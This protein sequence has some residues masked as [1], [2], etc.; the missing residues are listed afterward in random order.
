MPPEPEP[1]EEEDRALPDYVID[2]SNP[3]PSAPNRPPPRS[4]APS[5]KR[6][7]RREAARGDALTGGRPTLPAGYGVPD[8]RADLEDDEEETRGNRRP[9]SSARCRAT[10]LEALERAAEP[11]DELVEANWMDGLSNR[12]SAYSL[13]EDEQPLTA[14]R[15]TTKR[16]AE[17]RGDIA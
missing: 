5:S 9:T 2:P 17:G 3:N 7:A 4:P 6:R 1:E 15:T 16:R 14:T 10:E 8:A 13:S 12:L 11:G